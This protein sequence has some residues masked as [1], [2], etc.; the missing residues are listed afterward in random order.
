MPKLTGTLRCALAD[1]VGLGRPGLTF[2]AAFLI[3]LFSCL[4]FS[5]VYASRLMDGV[6]DLFLRISSRLSTT[7]STPENSP[8]VIIALDDQTIAQPGLAVPELFQHR[9]YSTIVR[10]LH[11][12]G[13][14][15]T[16]LTR[17][18]SRD[19]DA[20]AAPEDV[21]DWFQTILEVKD[22]M[23]VLSGVLWLPDRLLTP[24]PDYITFMGSENFGF[25]NVIRDSDSKIRRLGIRQPDCRS[26][27]GCRSL[28]YKAALLYYP[29]LPKPE[30]VIYID[31]DPR[32]DSV[33]VFSFLE[34][35]QKALADDIGYFDRNFKGRLVLIGEINAHSKGYLPTPFSRQTKMGDTEVEIISQ[36]VLTLLSGSY[37]ATFSYWKTFVFVVLLTWL[38]LLPLFF[39]QNCGPY[40][41]LWLPSALVAPFL[42]ISLAAFAVRLLLPVLPVLASL[43]MAQLFCLAVRGRELRLATKTSLAALN[44]Y[45]SPVLASQIA[46]HPELLARV[47]QRREMTVF[48][49]DL[50]GFTSMTEQIEPE[51]LVSTLNNYFSGMEPIIRASGGILD[52]FNGDSIMAF[53]GSP[54]MPLPEHA[55]AACL[56]ALEQRLALV[57]LNAAL[58]A[59]S[60]APLTALMA[61][62]SGPM[63]VG[64]I[65]A[66]KRF[67]YTVM[68]DPVNLASRLVAVNKIYK[69]EIMVS[70]R[71]FEQA[72]EVAEFRLIDRVTVSG[73]SESLF[74]YELMGNKGTLSDNARKGRELYEKG[75]K[76]YF[77]RE[78]TKALT[79]FEATLRFIHMDGP[80]DLMVRRC[81]GYILEPPPESWLGISSLD[82]K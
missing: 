33:P 11:Q 6:Y 37:L 69:T 38:S 74:I 39:S 16:V 7:Q 12:G 70:D 43:V 22:E 62:A 55:S 63:V 67:N 68:G 34:V 29:D 57:R 46:H 4:L 45:I 73:R 30:N 35:Y 54:L 49:S 60:R 24:D 50:V 64:N 59:D 26:L 15:A 51:E 78:F 81:R 40:P 42:I 1:D 32:P 18:L 31:Y 77:E 13:A 48:F 28:A 56:A 71:V 47:G 53:W 5:S 65:G 36:A 58:T 44:L 41:K 80:A 20:F 79:M 3:S 27:L 52:K 21:K 82:I 76:L 9:Y 17:V 23:P 8:V 75:L 61:M 72:S 10:S 2:S 25:L 66:E 14:R 19:K